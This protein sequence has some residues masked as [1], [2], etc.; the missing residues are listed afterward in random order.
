MTRPT[1]TRKTRLE[2]QYNDDSDDSGSSEEEQSD[3][4]KRPVKR[5]KRITNA[6]ESG[7]E[8]S[9]AKTSSVK[10]RGNAGKLAGFMGANLD[11]QYKVLLSWVICE[12]ITY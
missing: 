7:P 3:E 6:Q 12:W 9:S 1:R 8:T 2:I 4:P 5:V 10:R 11:V